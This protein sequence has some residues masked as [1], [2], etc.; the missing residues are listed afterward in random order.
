ML[1]AVGSGQ[2]AVGGGQL[3]PVAHLN[4]ESFQVS[5]KYSL[6]LSTLRTNPLLVNAMKE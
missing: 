4:Q 3:T 5:S 2:W 1:L 6:F